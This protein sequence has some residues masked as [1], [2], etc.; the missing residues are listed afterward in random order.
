[1]AELSVRGQYTRVIFLGV[2]FM[3]MFTSFNSLQNIVSKLYE[4]YHYNNMGQT[5]ILFLYAAFG[6][7]TFFTSFI[8]KTLGYKKTLFFSSL[9]Y[10]IFEATGLIIVTGLKVPK[11]LVWVIIITGAIICGVSASALW[12]A[13][14]AYTS[15]VASENRKSELFGL[16]WGLMMSSQILGNLLTTFILGKMSNTVYFVLLTILGCTRSSIQSP[17]PCSSCSCPALPRPS[18]SRRR[19]N[20]TP[21]KKRCAKCGPSPQTPSTSI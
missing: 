11:E 10:A 12:V 20:S 16:F 17:A 6:I 14:G 8:V 2:S 1:M 5:A 19:P 18:P 3:I 15:A 4:E 13:Q 9:G 7:S 21:S